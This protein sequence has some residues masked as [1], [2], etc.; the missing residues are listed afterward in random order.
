M[1]SLVD[2]LKIWR[3]Y[4][5]YNKRFVIVAPATLLVVAYTGTMMSLRTTMLINTPNTLLFIAV[6]C[7]V[8][9]LMAN[10]HAGADVFKVLQAWISAF[11]VLTMVTNVLCSGKSTFSSN[12]R[13]AKCLYGLQGRLP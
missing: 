12:Q 11:F 4:D 7:I 1:V 2:F 6:A 13:Y 5:L 9:G 3:T 8:L 10:L